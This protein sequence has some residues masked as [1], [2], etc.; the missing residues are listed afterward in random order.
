LKVLKII[1]ADDPMIQFVHKS[2][3]YCEIFLAAGAFK[4]LFFK[5]KT[6]NNLVV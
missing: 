3:T 4:I 5:R 2:L 1:E 6:T